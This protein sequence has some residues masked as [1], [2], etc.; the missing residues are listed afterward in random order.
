MYLRLIFSILSLSWFSLT[1]LHAQ[2]V[3]LGEESELV[4]G[5][6]VKYLLLP[7]KKKYTLEEIM[8]DSLQKHFEKSTQE[9]LNFSYQ[10]GEVW[11]RFSL[12][13]QGGEKLRY[14]LADA[15]MAD[16]LDF[17]WRAQSQTEWQTLFTGREKKFSSRGDQDHVGYILPLDFTKS[18]RIDFYIRAHSASPLILPLYVQTNARLDSYT[19]HQHIYY[20]F[21]FGTL[22]VMLLYNLFIFISLRDY[23]YLAYSLAIFSTL[24]VFSSVSGYSF[25]YVFP[26]HPELNVYVI[27]SFM[28]LLVLFM[29]WFSRL[30]L[31]VKKLNLWLDRWF[32][33]IM[34]LGGMG[35]LSAATGLSYNF[36][37]RVVSLFSLSVCILAVWALLRN[38]IAARFYALAWFSYIVGGV[39]I[40]LR[41]SGIL[42]MSVFTTHAAEVG[43]MFEIVLLSLALAERYRQYRKEKEA[44]TELA[45]KIQ[46]E[47]NENL[48]KKVKERTQEL[49]QAN[50]NANQINEELYTTL[51]KVQQQSEALV[52]MHGEIQSSINYAKRI[53]QAMLPRP[54]EFKKFFEEYFIFFQP[55][56]T[57][58]GDFYFIIEEDGYVFLGAV[59]CTGHGVP[60]G[61]MSM[62]GMHLLQEIILE[63]HEK[64]PGRVLDHLHYAVQRSL[65]QKESGNEDGMDI[66]MVVITP[67]KNE[68]YFAG[69]RNPLLGIQGDEIIYIQGERQSIGG[70]QDL[71]PF[72]THT[73]TLDGN[74]RFFLYSDGYQDQFGGKENKKYM[75]RSFR[76]KLTDLAHLPMQEVKVSLHDELT[77]WM[78][79]GDEFQ[80]DDILV[81]GFRA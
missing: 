13:H 40:T 17:F 1:F 74:G 10:N 22:V 77:E 38:V 67:S 15:P 33:V 30:F 78:K 52:H 8:Q 58:S 25:K 6:K 3:T 41:N 55:R 73:V 12:K 32:I 39:A 60:G 29:G 54:E 79:E 31:E 44:A 16:G 65:H 19:R 2:E 47:A 43:S 72:V 70:Q 21:Y 46:E 9:H 28:G 42:P 61:F 48:E 81:L 34:V 24:V 69:A 51:E 62:V 64:D 5:S 18:N 7:K 66:A 35:F 57:V 26:N 68:M 49:Q 63:R 71:R 59:D 36:P 14:L 37:N 4:L 11:L 50:A 75:S 20:G 45:L 76:K 56:D 23:N 53:Q 80:I 27:K